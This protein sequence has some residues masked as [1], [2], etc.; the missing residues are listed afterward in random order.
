[1][2]TNRREFIRKAGLAK[3]CV[4]TGLAGEKEYKAFAD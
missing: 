1:M 3:L 2:N 4:C